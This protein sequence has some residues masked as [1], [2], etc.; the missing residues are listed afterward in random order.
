[1]FPCTCYM[2]YCD[3]II[4]SRIF[5]ENE[6]RFEVFHLIYGQFKILC[7]NEWKKLMKDYMVALNDDREVLGVLVKRIDEQ[8]MARYVK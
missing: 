3:I 8:L 2:R 4:G 7:D 5:G 1:M 6:S